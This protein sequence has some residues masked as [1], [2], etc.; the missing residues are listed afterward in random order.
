MTLEILFE[1]I[2][3]Q[4]MKIDNIWQ[5]YLVVHLGIFWFFFLMH[6]PL[7]II[8]R[9]IAMVSYSIFCVINGS[10]LV[11]SYKYLEA[12]RR[13]TLLSFADGLQSVPSVTNVLSQWDFSGR[14]TVIFITH[15]G[16]W[17]LVM[18]IMLFRNSMVAYY[19]RHYPPQQTGSGQIAL[20]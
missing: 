7:L 13:D 10:S 17:L 9:A 4:A 1:T 5:M 12:L 6:R 8:E 16:A 20:D 11:N 14:L 18:L 15:G 19:Y 2:Q 3:S